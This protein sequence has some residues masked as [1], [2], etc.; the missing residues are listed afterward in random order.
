[1]MKTRSSEKIHQK[2]KRKNE[3]NKQLIIRFPQDVADLIHERNYDARLSVQFIDS[4]N[5]KCQIF[6]ESFDAVLVS[7]PTI[8]ETFRTTDGYHLFK[9]G[10]ITDILL[11]Y[12]EGEEPTGISSDYKYAHGITPPTTDIVVKRKTKQ[13]A[14]AITHHESF[15]DDIEYWD[16]AELQI[17]SLMSKEKKLNKTQRKEIFEEPDIDPVILEKVL[18]KN[19]YSEYK[20]YSGVEISQEEVDSFDMKDLE[21]YLSQPSHYQNSM[22]NNNSNEQSSSFTE[23]DSSEESESTT[24]DFRNIDSK[25]S[26]NITKSSIK[27][28]SEIHE[29][30]NVSDKSE[31]SQNLNDI[32]VEIDGYMKNVNFDGFFEENEEEEDSIEINIQ[33]LM[34]NKKALLTELDNCKLQI[35]TN[36]SNSVVQEKIKNRIST[37]EENIKEIDDKIRDMEKK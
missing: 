24:D 26:K 28:V 37:I 31:N 18:R 34:E 13:Q 20:G 7:L 10:E 32:E 16:L 12:R 9:S 19:G 11:V 30:L 3:L 33:K 36:A 22:I 2:V 15:L 1:M 14:I 8:V 17:T 6:D 21:Y 4:N 5:A 27:N 25:Q 35:F 29:T 23:S